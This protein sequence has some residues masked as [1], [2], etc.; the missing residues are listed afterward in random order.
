MACE[1]LDSYFR[2]THQIMTTRQ[3]K[4]ACGGF[5]SNETY[6]EYITRWR[7]ER[8]EMTGVLSTLLTLHNH[9]ESFAKT[10]DLLLGT[11]SNQLQM[12]PIDFS[13][14]DEE[15]PSIV[16]RPADNQHEPVNPDTA[17]THDKVDA[18]FSEDHSPERVERFA[19]TAAQ[20]S[21][22]RFHDRDAVAASEKQ[23]RAEP[24]D[25]V[26][27]SDWPAPMSAE[28]EGSSLSRGDMGSRQ[29]ALPLGTN[30][31]GTDERETVHDRSSN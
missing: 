1:R 4:A 20:A 2:K 31:S 21:E 7:A 28:T 17:T 3:L 5:G 22:A 15:R 10:T 14:E 23:H 6:L 27:P 30:Q 13:A 11:L 26:A 19:E 12:C 29:A 8:V 16:E 25:G 24:T 18:Q 9:M